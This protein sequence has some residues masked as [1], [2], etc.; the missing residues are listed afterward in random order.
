MRKTVV[1][2]V[3]LALA[4]LAPPAGMMLHDS[5]GDAGDPVAGWTWDEPASRATG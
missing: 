1:I 4:L 5:L 2:V 3:L